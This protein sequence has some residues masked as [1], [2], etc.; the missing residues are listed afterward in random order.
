MWGYTNPFAAKLGV[1]DS[2][3]WWKNPEVKPFDTVPLL[4][5]PK[6]Q[7]KHDPEIPFWQINDVNKV[8]YTVHNF[9]HCMYSNW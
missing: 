4:A 2:I 1:S 9:V 8:I 7:V 3:D 6:V 5:L